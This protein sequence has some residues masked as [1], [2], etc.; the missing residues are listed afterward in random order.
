VDR[1]GLA[2][3]LIAGLRLERTPFVKPA[4]NPI[5][6]A[7]HLP[8]GVATLAKVAALCSLAL[9][10][11]SA[12]ADGHETVGPTTIWLP[13]SVSTFGDEVDNMFYFILWLT[14]IINILVFIAMGWFIFKYRYN[15]NRHATFIHGNNKLETVWT[16]VPTVILV[17]IAVFS[18]TSWSKIKMGGANLP[19]GDIVEMEVVGRQFAWYFH[20]AGKDGK[21][22]KRK[23]ETINPKGSTPEDLI[24]LDR[25][26]KDSAD[27]LIT[28]VMYIPVDSNVRIHLTSVDVI[29]SFFLPNFRVKQDAMPGLMGT[30]WLNSQKTSAEI[31]GRVSDKDTSA[32]DKNIFGEQKPKPFDIVC[33]EL[34]GQGHFKM[35]GQMYVVTKDEYGKWMQNEI[36][37]ADSAGE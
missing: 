25:R 9:L 3:R 26:D 21:L 18:Q 1:F 23:V 4:V 12:F 2:S 7:R 17:L 5:H 11:G 37:K 19:S 15:A 30:V 27:D 31:V 22:G 14:G 32:A 35:R 29:H 6:S 28:S 34:C 8:L 33:A 20:Y 10:S 24:G 36:S 13:Q 16:L